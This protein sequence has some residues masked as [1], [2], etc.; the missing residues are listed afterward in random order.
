MPR[1]AAT[2]RKSDLTRAAKSMQAAG[3][4]VAHYEIDR[5]GKI[6][7]IPARD[8]AESNASTD[9][10]TPEDLRKQI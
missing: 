5:E 10:E 7:I 2:F 3:V 6:T 9:T 1:T 4:I 8:G